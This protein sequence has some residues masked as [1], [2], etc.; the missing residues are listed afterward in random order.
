VGGEERSASGYAAGSSLGLRDMMT[1]G[2][3][4]LLLT[5]FSL[6]SRGTDWWRG[7]GKRL[8]QNQVNVVKGVDEGVAWDGA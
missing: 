8:M 2:T 6:L 1:L 4:G 5:F 3:E 7:G